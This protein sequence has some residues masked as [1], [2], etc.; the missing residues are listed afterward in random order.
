M[1]NSGT[2]WKSPLEVTALALT[3]IAAVG[4]WYFAYNLQG[5]LESQ[6]SAP[7]HKSADSYNADHPVRNTQS[8]SNLAK[9]G[10]GFG[11]SK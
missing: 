5:A 1:S 3:G 11:S 6:A 8:I 10:L 2:N 7:R 4:M 9:T